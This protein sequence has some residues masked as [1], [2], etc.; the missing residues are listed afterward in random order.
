MSTTVR[1]STRLSGG[2]LV[3]GATAAAASLYSGREARRIDSTEKVLD[4]SYEALLANGW[5]RPDVRGVLTGWLRV[6]HSVA[7]VLV[8]LDAGGAAD[9]IHELRCRYSVM[10]LVKRRDQ[11]LERA[12]GR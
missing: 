4:R 12:L 10:A 8:D 1:V 7:V 2:Q 11:L 3:R 5:S 6:A 9:L